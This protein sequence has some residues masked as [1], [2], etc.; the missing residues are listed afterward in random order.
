M[1]FYSGLSLVWALTPPVF[2]A[3]LY[4]AAI[5]A[6]NPV[7]YLR[8]SAPGNQDTELDR[9]G[10]GNH[11]TYFPL[12]ANFAKTQ[13]PNGEAAT[14]FDGVNQYLEVPSAPNLSVKPGGALTIE[15]WIRPDTLNFSHDESD[16]YVHWAGKGE[17]GQHEYVL[18]MYSRQNTAGRPN[19]ISG[20]AFNPQGG[21]GSGAY[22]QDAVT[23]GQ[24]MHI[25]VVISTRTRPGTIRIY[26][27]GLLRQ[28]TP[29]DQFHVVPRAGNAPLRIGTRD[30]GSFFKGA[31]GK[32]A[33][34]AHPL[35]EAQLRNHYWKMP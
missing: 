28:T 5:L 9:S 32:V 21:L 33:V 22:F 12:T 15:A 6:D 4:D 27:N 19:R 31:I 10:R 30:F 8:L 3:S 18:R 16:G 26:K 25:A 11:G 2:A 24:W 1:A 29:L 35:T 14:V 20:Y 7:L 23:A 34:Y 17:S 13:L